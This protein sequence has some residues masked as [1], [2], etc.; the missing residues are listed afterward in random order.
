MRRLILLGVAVTGYPWA[1]WQIALG[2]QVGFLDL[3]GG[4]AMI[5]DRV[6]DDFWAGRS[7][8]GMDRE[9]E[10]FWY[11]PPFVVLFG[12]LA[13]LNQLGLWLLTVACQTAALRYMGG[14][15]RGV[16]LLLWFPLVPLELSSG[17]FNL[18]VAASIVAAVRGRGELA[19]L[20]ALAKL[21]PALAIHPRDWRPALA[22]IALL[23]AVSLP[24]AWLWP[25]YVTALI[26]AYGQSIGPAVPIPFA[27]RFV[28]ALGL[29]ALWRPWSRALAAVVA[30]PSFYWSSVAVL[31]APAV[32]V[33]SSRSDKGDH[34]PPSR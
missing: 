10:S 7:P 27:G 32:V 19:A 3:P 34:T 5:W 13:P 21:S 9:P 14:S 29:L 25:E 12:L 1:V 22:V 28:L 23:V 15:W 16:G 31:V 6:G 2:V 4:D 26:G 17:G 33:S 30:I 20:W 8:Y 18:I 24:W 11:A